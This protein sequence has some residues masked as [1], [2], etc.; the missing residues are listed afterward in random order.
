MK[1]RLKYSVFLLVGLIVLNACS[2]ANTMDNELF[3]YRGSYIGDN[4][5]VLNIIKQLPQNKAFK[6]LTLATKEEPYG[7]E[8]EYGDLNVS[9]KEKDQV[10]KETVI[11][12]ATY[13]FA[14]IKNAEWV[15]F[16]FNGQ[17]YRVTRTKLENW[18]G[19]KLKVYTNEEDLKKAIQDNLDNKNKVNQFY[20]KKNPT[21]K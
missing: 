6:K 4:S 13:L 18:Y 3:K 11:M 19:T 15:T 8:V 14:L 12:N 21:K 20:E 7:M 1:K 16:D 10:I 2:L 5:A 17:K 9:D